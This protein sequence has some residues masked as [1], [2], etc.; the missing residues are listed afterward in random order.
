MLDADATHIL[1]SRSET[2]DCTVSSEAAVTTTAIMAA[3]VSLPHHSSCTPNHSAEADS[4]VEARVEAHALS[5]N[6]NI[7]SWRLKSIKEAVMQE[8]FAHFELGET[9]AALDG[10]AHSLALEQRQRWRDHPFTAAC[11][12]NLGGCLHVMGRFK[13]AE[14]WY[15]RAFD[16]LHANR[17]RWIGPLLV[18][19]D[20]YGRMALLGERLAEVRAGLLPGQVAK[21]E[22]ASAAMG[23]ALGRL[24]H[25]CTTESSAGASNAETEDEV[26]TT[27]VSLAAGATSTSETPRSCII[28]IKPE[29]VKRVIEL[30]ADTMPLLQ[31]QA[32]QK[33]PSPPRGTI[34][35]VARPLVPPSVPI[36]FDRDY[37]DDEPRE[38]G[39]L[40]WL[41][42][43]WLYRGSSRGGGRYAAVER[44]GDDPLA[45]AEE[46][47][48]IEA[49]PRRGAPGSDYQWPQYS[50]NYSQD[51][52]ATM[53]LDDIE[54]AAAAWPPPNG[55]VS[56]SQAQQD[57]SF[58][59][60]DAEEVEEA[61]Q[62][63]S[64]QLVTGRLPPRSALVQ[65]PTTGATAGNTGEGGEGGRSGS[66]KSGR[67]MKT[68]PESGKMLLNDDIENI[69]T[70]EEADAAKS[71][72]KAK[73][74][75]EDGTDPLEEMHWLLRM[76]APSQ[77]QMD[78]Q[79]KLY[80]QRAYSTMTNM[81]SG[82]GMWGAGGHS[83]G[84]YGGIH[85]GYS[86]GL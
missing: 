78:L 42:L 61:N 24:S 81:R 2:L 48:D 17:M 54:A 3:F 5:I 62:A 59:S 68:D 86:G 41:G 69:A 60:R 4:A 39:L 71:L 12:Y 9:D 6:T 53:N 26:S 29:Q 74:A 19:Q 73:E 66:P 56:Q 47:D 46:A 16:T 20:N 14:V 58:W 35:G 13:A 63:A 8:A 25:T 50:M 75:I 22:L 43:G 51:G 52:G 18:G 57:D 33:P 1:A 34:G 77:Q 85:H 31:S 28:E 7:S 65:E 45:A 32:T 83:G 15:K 84:M 44:G 27:S 40:S 38:S 67:T 23:N 80:E 36:L 30:P 82:P 11:E 49:G 10:F 37:Y 76:F 21:E 79:Q 70:D 55:L 64:I 72:V